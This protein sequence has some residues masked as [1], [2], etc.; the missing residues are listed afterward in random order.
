MFLL[1]S[2]YL[3]SRLERIATPKIALILA[4]SSVITSFRRLSITPLS[5]L[6]GS[7]TR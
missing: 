7:P 2:G 1:A 4:R 6:G 5:R 3:H